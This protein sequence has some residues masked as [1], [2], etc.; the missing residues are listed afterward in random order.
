M[1]RKLTAMFF[2]LSVAFVAGSVWA[3]DATDI[4]NRRQDLMKRQSR[5]LA[6]VKNFLDGKGD[7]AAAQAA[8]ADLVQ[9]TS[10]IPALFPKGTGMAEFPDKSA[11]K[12]LIWTEPNKFSEAQKNAASKAVV[13]L[14]TLKSVDK[15]AINVAFDAMIRGGIWDATNA[16]GGCHVPFRERRS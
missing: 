5:D 10:S 6:A 16:C 14:E 11:A 9:T 7:V 2:G 15:T 8:A 1:W 13:L 12:P 4:I 3:Q